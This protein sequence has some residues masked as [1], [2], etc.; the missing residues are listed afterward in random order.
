M[1]G[2][3][4]LE[5]IKNRN[6]KNGTRILVYKN[7]EYVTTLIYDDDL[8]WNTGSFRT[9]MLWD[10]NYRFYCTL[11]DE[12]EDKSVCQYSVVPSYF[13]LQSAI[14][15]INENFEKHQIAINQLIKNQKVLKEKL[16]VLNDNNNV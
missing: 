11:E 15:T 9:R 14:K 1:N 6:I 5:K 8:N 7:N 2:I 16:E 12:C 10:N 4:L 13:D 3:E